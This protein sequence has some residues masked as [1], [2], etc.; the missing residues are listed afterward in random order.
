MLRIFFLVPLFIFLTA[1]GGAGGDGTDNNS[2]NDSVDFSNWVGTTQTYEFITYKDEAYADYVCL[3]LDAD[4][5]ILFI[6]DSA[7]IEKYKPKAIGYG[8][9]QFFGGCNAMT[10]IPISQYKNIDENYLYS[11]IIDTSPFMQFYSCIDP[12]GDYDETFQSVN[13]SLCST[14]SV[15]IPESK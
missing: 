9:Y 2:D 13:F 12:A 4:G 3:Q 5:L 15:P 1:C 10:D 8:Y 11:R 7:T 6:P 14:M